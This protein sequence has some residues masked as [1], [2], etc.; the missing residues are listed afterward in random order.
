LDKKI[1]IISFFIAFLMLLVPIVSSNS[2]NHNTN[3][4]NE[5]TN[6]SCIYTD[7]FEWY[8]EDLY[9]KCPIMIDP[10]PMEKPETFSI[11]KIGNP[12]SSYSWLD[13]DGHDWTTPARHQGQCG[14][15]WAFAPVAMIESII[16]IRE[17]CHRLNVD[18]SEQYLLSCIK[19]AGSC[20]G[21]NS[22]LALQLINDTTEKGNY[23]NGIPIESCLPYQESDG[24]SC[25]T[26]CDDWLEKLIPISDFG[27]YYLEVPDQR[28]AIKTE[29][30]ENGPVVAPIFSTNNFGLWGLNHHDSE[31]YYSESGNFLF[32]NHVI[33]VVGW[34][35][36]PQ[37][38]NGGYWICKN[39]W[40]SYWGYNGFFNIEYGSLNVDRYMVTWVE[41]DPD[42]YDWPPIADAGHPKG[43][44]M[45][46]EL[47]FNAENSF[48]AEGEIMSYT[49]DFGDQQTATGPAVSHKYTELGEYTVTL[50]VT[51]NSGQKTTDEIQIWIQNSNEPSPAPLVYG[52]NTHNLG[53]RYPLEIEG[54]DPEG[55]DLY[56]YIDWGDGT[57]EE[58]IGPYNSGEKIKATHIWTKPGAYNV[59]IKTKDVFDAESKWT[60]LQINM[61]KNKAATKNLQIPVFTR[62][63]KLFP[64]LRTIFSIIR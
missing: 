27:F 60:E 54:F 53:S 13:N 18:L 51:D 61:L 40:G 43:A 31:A 24:I 9:N 62:L 19:Q 58:W 36:D 63:L 48:D 28:L 21:G 20:R 7:V 44:S 30:Y 3:L 56:Y 14:S 52:K 57:K 26:K 59:K 45:D 8:G 47:F 33:L 38:K 39:S 37:I 49:W 25:D 50:T 4:K 29:I 11:P 64:I 32:F 22:N 1:K 10:V 23:H 35:D 16:K 6:D 5:D 41:Y 2:Q 42:D 15:C 34:K 12:P 55:N 17:N 46:E